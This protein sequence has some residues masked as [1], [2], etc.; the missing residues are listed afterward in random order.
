MYI[1]IILELSTSDQNGITRMPQEIKTDSILSPQFQSLHLS[2]HPHFHWCFQYQCHDLH[3]EKPKRTLNSISQQINQSIYLILQ[4]YLTY[5]QSSISQQIHQSI[6]SYSLTWHTFSH[7]SVNKSI[8]KSYSLTWH[9]F[10]LQPVNKSIN[11][12]HLTVLP[13]ISSVISQSTNHS[14]SQ[15]YLHSYLT[16]PQSTNHSISQSYLHSYLTHLPWAPRCRL[17]G[18]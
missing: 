18:T 8:S 2:F 10:S 1:I 16:H 12:S 13:N 17:V 5:L 11:L 9:I 3:L 6:S 14:I 7:Q 4:S 15:S